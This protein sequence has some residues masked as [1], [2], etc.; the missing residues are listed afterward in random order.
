MDRRSSRC[1]GSAAAAARSA[2]ISRLTN[3]DWT[4]AATTADQD[5]VS[6]STTLTWPDGDTSERE[7]V[8]DIPADE[9]LERLESFVATLLNPQGGAG[10]GGRSSGIND[11]RRRLSG[12]YV[13]HRPCCQSV[14]ENSNKSQFVVY[15]GLRAGNGFGDSSHR[16]EG[17]R[18]AAA[19]M[20]RTP[21]TLT[22]QDGDTPPR[23]VTFPPGARLGRR[24][25]R[26][27][28]RGAVR[29]PQGG[30][31]DRNGVEC[32]GDAGRRP[33]QKPESP[34][35]GGG[36]FDLLLAAALGLCAALRRRI[37]RAP[38]TRDTGSMRPCSVL[39]A[40]P[41][42]VAA[43]PGRPLRRVAG[44]CAGCPRARRRD[45]R[46]CGARRR[47]RSADSWTSA[48]CTAAMPAGRSVATCSRIARCRLRCRNG[49]PLHAPGSSHASAR[50]R[51]QGARGTRGA[52]R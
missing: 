32:Q 29:L 6:T 39:S 22:W 31:R 43:T 48:A 49:L 27:T 40:F 51:R 11:T 7:F 38:S 42:D 3:V 44:L 9:G 1:A 30:A 25:A 5:F 26:N 34:R 14:E 21:V 20:T 17:Q 23:Y 41:A 24:V 15:R 46:S 16:W 12:G 19:T 50:H 4:G 36:S 37:R 45:I 33:P 10:L 47:A 52:R 28:D 35:G 8:I 2:S 13:Q 18:R